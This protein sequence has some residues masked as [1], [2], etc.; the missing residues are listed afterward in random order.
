[1]RVI[2]AQVRTTG[3]LQ[4]AL[5]DCDPSTQIQF[6]VDGYDEEGYP[7]DSVDVSVDASPLT[8]QIRI[9]WA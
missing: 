4:E 1:M 9:R 3:D 2:G 5:A 7:Y 8:A 6:D